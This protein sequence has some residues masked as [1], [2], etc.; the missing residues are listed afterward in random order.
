MR[1]RDSQE[2]EREIDTGMLSLT[3]SQRNFSGRCQTEKL[4]V[5]S[6]CFHTTGSYF[7]GFFP[8]LF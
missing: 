6:L 4:S 7:I 2:R 8:S 3:S 1:E 5:L